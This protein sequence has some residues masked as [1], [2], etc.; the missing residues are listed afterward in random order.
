MQFLNNGPDVPERLLQAHEDG[1]VVFFCGAGISFPAG[2]PGFR[3]LVEKLFDEVGEIQNDIEKTA[4]KRDQYDSVIGL[5]EQRIAGGRPTVRKHLGKI[6]R[7]NLSSPGAKQTHE[8][9][10]TLARTRGR[11]PRHRLVTTN[12]D[13]LFELTREPQVPTYCAPFLPVPKNRWNGLVYL[14]GLLP[15]ENDAAADDKLDQ[16]VLSSGDFGLAYLAE[17]W[18]ARFVGEVF[19]RYTVCFVGYSIN[20]PVLRYMMDALAADRLRGEK[21]LPETFAFGSHGPEKEK[22][23]ADEW[24]AKNV[25]PILY[26]ED[27]DGHISLHSTLHAWAETYRD[28]LL[29]KRRIIDTYAMA[30]PQASTKEDD[31]VGRVLWALSDP[32][33]KPAQHFA[34]LDPPPHL[35]WLDVLAERRFGRQHLSS[36]GISPE[37]EPDDEFA[38]GM[39]ERP[40]RASRTPPMSIVQRGFTQWDEIMFHLGRW[41][42]K[43]LDKPELLLWV[44][45]QSLPLHPQFAGLVARRLDETPPCPPMQKLWRLMLAGK[46][47]TD[48][49]G[50][51]Y[52]WRRRV[53]RDGLTLT[54]R[55][56]LRELLTP[57][58]EFRPPWRSPDPARGSDAEPAISD[59]VDWET[60][61]GADHVHSMLEDL[62]KSLPAGESLAPLLPDLTALLRDAL[63]LMRELEGA[64]DDEDPSSVWHPSISEH[65]QNKHYRDWTTLIDLARD[66]WLATANTCPHRASV[67]IESWLTIPYPLFKRLAFF[68]ATDERVVTP[69][70][71]LE[72][73]LIDDCRWLWSSETT[74]EAIRLIVALAP[75]LAPDDANILQGAILHGPPLAADWEEWLRLAKIRA[76]GAPL[77]EAANERLQELSE[78]YPYLEL[79]DDERDEFRRGWASDGREWRALVAAPTELGELV[80]WLRENPGSFGAWQEDDWRDRCKTDVQTTS[81]ALRRLAEGNEWPTMRWYQALQ[82][83]SDELLAERSYHD[84]GPLLSEAPEDPLKELANPLG[85]WLAAVARTVGDDRDALLTLARRVL[86]LHREGM[87][88][89]TAHPVSAAINHPVGNVTQAVLAWWYHQGLEDNQGMNDEIRPILGGLCETSVASFRHGRLIL[90]Q[91]AITLIRV[92]P[93]WTT[94]HVLPLFDW[95]QSEE[96]ARAAWCGFLWTAR[97]YGPFL[98]AVKPRFI[99]TSAHYDK[100]GEFAEN[101]AKL[102][103][104][105]AMEP[106][107]WFA[108]QELAE[109]TRL[110]PEEG[111]SAALRSVAQSLRGAGE[112][113]H[114]YWQNRVLPYLHGVW[115]KSADVFTPRISAEFVELCIAAGDRFP[116]AVEVVHKWLRPIS[117]SSFVLSNVCNLFNSG[118]CKDF[119]REALTLLYAV[120]QDPKEWDDVLPQCLDGIEKACPALAKDDRMKFL[121][122]R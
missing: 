39:L 1:H 101:Y 62:Q 31:F 122:G 114:E 120:V 119:P 88:E 117:P 80:A 77:T 103:A 33:G 55:L 2:L 25:T 100:L 82:A 22:E 94:A 38:F 96:E 95:E 32:S 52:G 17:G 45:K 10:L 81:A 42:V 64:T 63:D 71:A 20:D 66:A 28:G 57:R 116:D 19:R 37:S 70:R 7:P 48:R 53:S 118:L 16:L 105:V 18:A 92:D 4:F 112:Q 108:E 86:A 98:V 44:A 27:D 51:F 121:R 76:A 41:L 97:L 30:R 43:H 46:V 36:F 109:A 50:E 72:W 107:D 21:D 65:P 5:L 87:P 8:A 13:H 9:L 40:G 24:R 111:L 115:P 61:L 49:H 3:G 26:A 89:Q 59:L 74:R 73:L 85:H 47:R 23:A 11:D 68:A 29:G 15:E 60:V 12:F 6:L 104:L 84:M 91:S 56:E 93:D 90:A 58:L 14:H 113:H 69:G 99:A 34:D 67:E 78:K 35:D 102:L 110:M 83:W 75:K 106:G 79:A 54:L